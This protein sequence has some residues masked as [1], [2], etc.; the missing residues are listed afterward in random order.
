MY[1]R[2]LEYAVCLAAEGQFRRAAAPPR[3]AMSASP[4]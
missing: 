1:L 4:P 2:D 3:V